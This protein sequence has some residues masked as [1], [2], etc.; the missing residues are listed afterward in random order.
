MKYWWS[1]IVKDYFTFSKRERTGTI[2][3]MIVVVAALFLIPKI[4]HPPVTKI[5]RTA[6]IK[7]IAELK[8][9]VDSSNSYKS[10]SRDNNEN[11]DFYQPKNTFTKEIKG[12]L[13]EFDPNTLSVDGW[14]RLGVR[15]R[16]IQTIQKFISKGYKFRQPRDIAKIYGIRQDQSA[17]LIPYIRIAA[18][19]TETHIDEAKPNFVNPYV[20][21]KSA[22]VIIDINE[23]DSSALVELPGIG[24]KLASRIINFRNKLGGFVSVAQVGETY[25]LPDSTFQLIKKQLQCQHPTVNT[26]N[27][28]TA[29]AKQLKAHP[30][31]SWNIAN[32]IVRYREQHGNYLSLADLQKIDII[33]TEFYQ[34]IN[35][36]LSL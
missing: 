7:Q 25:G 26:I 16:T 2:I 35:Q 11:I 31:M 23:A 13:F 8:I 34:K 5:D 27:I 18:S 29:D 30:Y 6:L 24:N 3:T 32:A 14:K 28:N 12:E 9:T 10:Y 4:F 1:S 22:P 36:Y 21:K 19:I 33:S 17:R 15:D 20:S